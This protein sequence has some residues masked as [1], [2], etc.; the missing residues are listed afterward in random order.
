MC[1]LIVHAD[2]FGLSEQVND[3]ILYAH[4]HGILTST[5]IMPNGAA[6]EHAINIC[7]SNPTLDLGIHLT[8][9]E[10][11]PILQVSTIPTL[12]N[13]AGKLHHHCTTFVKKYLLGKISTYEIQCELEAQVQQVVN[14]GISPSHIDSHQHLHMLPR[15][16]KIVINLAKKYNIPAIRVPYET[17]RYYMFKDLKSINRLLQLAILNLLTLFGSNLYEP[18]INH[19]FG[20]YY[21][22]NLNKHNLLN[23][24]QIL[25]SKGNFEIM[26]HPGFDDP[27]NCYNHWNYNWSDELNALIDP[28]I[29]RFSKNKGIRFISYRQL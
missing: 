12:I 10:E 24:L 1:N 15:I 9:V 17:L 28:D 7:R 5:S 23:I 26:C 3:G 25:P 19:F 18:H 29:G 21:S 27:N 6:F 20:F 4:L 11:K 22:G 16:R 8:L 2:D 13:G 14:Q